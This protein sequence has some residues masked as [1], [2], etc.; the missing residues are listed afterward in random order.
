MEP[1]L[2]A[3]TILSGVWFVFT[4]V[5]CF[6]TIGNSG[7]GYTPFDSSVIAGVIFT[8]CIWKYILFLG[9]LGVIF[10]LVALIVNIFNYAALE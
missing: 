8:I 5:L 1:T 9:I 2:L 7:D 10:S 3:V 6:I 4:L